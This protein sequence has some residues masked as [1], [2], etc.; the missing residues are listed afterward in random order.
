MVVTVVTRMIH[1][2]SNSHLSSIAIVAFS[3]LMMVGAIITT[4]MMVIELVIKSISVV[5]VI[6]FFR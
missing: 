6:L 4:E 3:V 5:M 2:C 1:I